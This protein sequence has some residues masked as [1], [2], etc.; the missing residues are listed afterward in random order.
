M[1]AKAFEMY[2]CEHCGALKE[3]TRGASTYCGDCRD[4]SMK[5]VFICG[6]CEERP[7][8]DEHSETCEKCRLA[9]F[10]ERLEAARDYAVN[11][12]IKM[13]KEDR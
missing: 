13:R 10:E 2:Q 12:G 9:E 1:T 8:E 7:V 3:L 4:D 5:S 6:A 11:R